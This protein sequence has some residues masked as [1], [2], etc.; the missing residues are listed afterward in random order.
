[1]AWDLIEEE[2]D[3]LELIENHCKEDLGSISKYTCSLFTGLS[4]K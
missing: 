4:S 1:M 2:I 3:E